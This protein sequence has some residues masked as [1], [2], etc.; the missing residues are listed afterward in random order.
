MHV[1]LIQFPAK[2]S[3]LSLICLFDDSSASSL[4]LFFSLCS[5]SDSV[6]IKKEFSREKKNENRSFIEARG[7]IV[8]HSV[9][10]RLLKRLF[11]SVASLCGSGRVGIGSES[12][13]PER[14]QAKVP[15]WIGSNL[16]PLL[17]EII[18]FS[19]KQPWFCRALL[20]DLWV[21]MLRRGPAVES[22]LRSTRVLIYL[23]ILVAIKR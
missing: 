7:D 16:S 2:I 19:L 21:D 5:S 4:A 20:H 6:T 8:V 10:A 12:G 11:L 13:R 18:T 15:R 22:S 1:D 14:F 17:A 3:C 23:K 9:T